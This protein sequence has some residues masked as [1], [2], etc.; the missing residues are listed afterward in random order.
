MSTKS[1]SKHLFVGLG[2]PGKRYAHTRHNFGVLVVEEFARSEGWIFLEDKRFSLK[3]AKGL[4][5]DRE[6]VLLLP[7]T[8]MNDSGWAVKCYFEYYKLHASQC[9]VVCDDIALEFGV[10]R[11][12]PQGTSGGHNGLKS[13]AAHLGTER[14]ARLRMGIR[15]KSI[16]NKEI[17]WP[18]AD[19]VLSDFSAEES[20]LLGT[21]VKKGAA[22][23]KSLVTEPI[24]KVMSQANIVSP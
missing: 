19:Y 13:I 3:V 11:L 23:L 14:F 20:A 10:L 24:A 16:E 2:N 1:S 22:L 8:Y 9:V 21:I 12:R 18:L 17:E 5:A 15:N 4:I 6:V 7:Q